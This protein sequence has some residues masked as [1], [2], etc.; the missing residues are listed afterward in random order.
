MRS[1]YEVADIL[2]GINSLNTTIEVLDTIESTFTVNHPSVLVQIQVHNE[3]NRLSIL[4]AGMAGILSEIVA[5]R[6]RGE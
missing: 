5:A 2:S 4:S 6:G 1:K 3:L